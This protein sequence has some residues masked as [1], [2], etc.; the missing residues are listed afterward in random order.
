MV[1][2]QPDFGASSPKTA[3]AGLSDIGELAARLGSIVTWDR[4]GD[5]EYLD[6]FESPTIKWYLMEAGTASVGE[7]SPTTSRSGSQSLKCTVG[8]LA[9]NLVGIVRYF[10]IIE[11]QREGFELSFAVIDPE[12]KLEMMCWHYDGTTQ[13]KAGLKIEF[14]DGKLYY[15]NSAG[16]WTNFATYYALDGGAYLFSTAK[17]VVDFKESKYVRLIIND[18]EYDLSA[19]ATD[20]DPSATIP[21]VYVDARMIAT[22]NGTFTAYI[23]DFIFTGNEP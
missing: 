21:E 7:L 16:G 14:D 20:D 2:G 3:G 19:Y 5:V 4:R 13:K 11:L 6:D 15:F 9:G 18:T 8:V 12:L 22:E 17:L 10:P 1:R 23:D